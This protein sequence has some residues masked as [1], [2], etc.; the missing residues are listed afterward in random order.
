[1]EGIIMDIDYYVLDKNKTE[2]EE[3]LL[4][5]EVL[6]ALNKN[7]QYHKDCNNYYLHS[8]ND[9]SAEFKKNYAVWKLLEEHGTH[10]LPIACVNKKIVKTNSLLD[11]FELSELTGFGISFQ[12]K[13]DDLI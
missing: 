1:M 9:S 12:Y 5:I 11:V 4:G 10:I 7:K 3:I 13:P 6:A 2:S 8:L